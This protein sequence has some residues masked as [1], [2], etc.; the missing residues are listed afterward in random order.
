MYDIKD[1]LN[2]GA[3]YVQLGSCF[4]DSFTNSLDYDKINSVITTY[5]NIKSSS[6]FST[7]IFSI[8]FPLASQIPIF[9]G[10]LY[11][12]KSSVFCF[13]Y[14]LIVTVLFSGFIT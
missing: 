8:R 1:Y 10:I 5:E 6:K 13:C 7:T 11:K 12:G 9:T 4:Y 14:T 2:N 3:N